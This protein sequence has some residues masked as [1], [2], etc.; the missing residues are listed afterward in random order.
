MRCVAGGGA[1]N[2]T[3]LATTSNIDAGTESATLQLLYGVNYTC[4]TVA[5]NP[6]E[7]VCSTGT[8]I[9]LTPLVSSQYNISHPD[10]RTWRVS[11]GNVKLNAG[12]P[13]LVYMYNGSDIASAGYVSMYVESGWLE[14]GGWVWHVGGH[15][16]LQF[17]QASGYS[18]YA[19]HTTD[20]NGWLGYDSASDL[21]TLS[22]VPAG[23]SFP[24]ADLITNWSITPAPPQQYVYS[25]IPPSAPG[26]PAAGV[27]LYV[28]KTS[29][30]SFVK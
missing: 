26:A 22:V 14:T 16:N 29:G 21:V 1:C 10:G 15:D 2:D 9:S 17:Y 11:S 25:L 19:I 4:Y 20:Q 27:S 3:V 30:S 13:E 7:N 12:T 8:D 5:L 28:F 6:M 24:N 18:G 23:G